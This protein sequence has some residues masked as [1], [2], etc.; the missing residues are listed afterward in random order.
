MPTS[1]FQV[2][3]TLNVFDSAGNPAQAGL[4]TTVET[5][6]SGDLMNLTTAT[7]GATID[8]D[9]AVELG[10][11]P[12]GTMEFALTNKSATPGEDIKVSLDYSG[13]HRVIGMVYAGDTRIFSLLGAPFVQ[14]HIANIPYLAVVAQR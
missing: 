10:S 3:C 2:Q 14:S 13:T 6:R 5:A 1:V 9:T 8:T 7:T 11:V 12:A 4:G